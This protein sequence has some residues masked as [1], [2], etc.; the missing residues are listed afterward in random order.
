MS[1]FICTD[2]QFATVARYLFS[3][4]TTRQQFADHLK[5]ENV[6]S[7]NDRYGE[8]T[9]FSRVNMAKACDGFTGHDILAMITCIQYQSIEHPTYESGPLQ[10]AERLLIATGAE[11]EQSTIWSI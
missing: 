10:L 2:R 11:R 4:K 8:K 7:V 6:R 5:R 3:D 1:A 9:R